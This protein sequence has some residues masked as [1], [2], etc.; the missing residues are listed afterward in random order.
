MKKILLIG[1]EQKA[2]LRKCSCLLSIVV[3]H[4]T[5]F[6][7]V[8]EVFFNGN[9]GHIGVILRASEE[10]KTIIQNSFKLF[11]DYCTIGV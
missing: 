2:T 1:K 7:I 10:G 11:I 5:N 3:T 6:N 9:Y 8:Y 4:H